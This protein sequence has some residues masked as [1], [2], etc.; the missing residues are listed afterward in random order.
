MKLVKNSIVRCMFLFE[1]YM[2]FTNIL[3]YYCPNRRDVIYEYLYT[4]HG[5]LRD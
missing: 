2:F 4:I 1:L 5:I 3:Q